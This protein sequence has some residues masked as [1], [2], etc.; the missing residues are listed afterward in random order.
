MI[1]P[2]QK[3]LKTKLKVSTDAQNEK[4]VLLLILKRLFKFNSKK[5]NKI[6]LY[7]KP[8]IKKASV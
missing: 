5:K 3:S 8:F 4:F 7:I 2:N 1:H 6:S